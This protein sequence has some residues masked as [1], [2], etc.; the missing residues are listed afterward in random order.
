MLCGA[1]TAGLL[2]SCGLETTKSSDTGSA[3][4]VTEE[5]FETGGIVVEG[6]S[7]VDPGKKEET[8]HVDADASGEPEEIS[9]EAVL[10]DIDSGDLIRDVSRLE[11]IRNSEGDE[12]YATQDH[13]IVLWENKS[14][15]IH[16][17]GISKDALPVNVTV[18]YYLDG[19]KMKPENMAG[20]S[21]RVRIRF[22]YENTTSETATVGDKDVKAAVPFAAISAVL[23]PEDVFSD[24]EVKNGKL[25]QV[26]DQ[27]MVIGY[28]VPGLAESLKLEDYEPTED[29]KLPEYVEITAQ[30]EDFEL[31]FTATIV[32][33][34]LFEDM[35][36]DDLTDADDLA[37]GMDELTDASGKLVDGTAELSNGGSKFG[38]YLSKYVDAVK[39]VSSGSQSLS[40]GLS[41]LDSQ[42]SKLQS[43]AA[44]LQQGLEKLNKSLSQYDLSK[45]SEGGKQQLAAVAKC[46]EALA[47][48]AKTLGAGLTSL[49]KSLEQ[50]KSFAKQAAAYE[51]AVQAASAAAKQALEQMNWSG[52]EQQAEAKAK[53]QAK[54]AAHSAL[55]GAELTEEQ[56]AQLT[57]AIDSGI[58]Q[59]IDLSGSTDSLKAEAASAAAKLDSVPALE[60][61]KLELDVSPVRNAVSD[62]QKQLETMQGYSSSL[63]GIAKQLTSISSALDT[64]KSGISQLATGSAQLTAGIKTYGSAVGQV[65]E[66]AHKLSSGLGQLANSGVELE[67]AYQTLAKGMKTLKNGI[68]TFDEEGIRSL[69][70]LAGDDLTDMLDRVR[71][72]KKIDGNYDNFSGLGEDTEGSVR[73]VIET[74]SI[75]KDDK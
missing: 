43:G 23:L 20:K 12:E 36:T 65:S 1:L 44:S 37:E 42:K 10:S 50:V 30:A 38:E 4:V 62:M 57:Q 72:L 21:G 19:K 34:G 28:A 58:D 32:T 16:Y 7:I 35:D 71:A 3:S 63:Q 24:I 11:G 8:V 66:G 14:A 59:S 54:A 53:G 18:S 9:V 48:D 26:D 51:Q 60:I 56:R 61:P 33:P 5:A 40:R 17:E 68:A 15:D 2:A 29:V 45:S 69:S 27:S 75:E 25:V 70:D 13:D 67:K 49:N 41:T 52:A 73:F 74:D 22:D 39:Q 64:L 47:G 6:S 46:V 55:S 31:D